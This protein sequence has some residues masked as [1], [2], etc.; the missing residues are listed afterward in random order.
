[1]MVASFVGASGKRRAAYAKSA[2]M[3]RTCDTQEYLSRGGPIAALWPL[4]ASA[5]RR[6]RDEMIT[7]NIHLVGAQQAVASSGRYTIG[8][9]SL[10][11]SDIA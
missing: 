4:R 7:A 11:T 3:Q 1:M 8:S 10:S 5:T 9:F 6:T 2:A